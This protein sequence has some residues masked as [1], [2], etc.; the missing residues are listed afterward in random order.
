LNGLHNAK[1][2]ERDALLEPFLDDYTSV[3]QKEIDS[4]CKRINN[5]VVTREYRTQ[6]LDARLN[7]S[8]CE[9]RDGSYVGPVRSGLSKKEAE[10]LADLLNLIVT[11]FKIDNSIE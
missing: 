2:T 7:Y 1:A 10:S 9:Y 5:P 4:L 3:T 8:V 11:R 6:C